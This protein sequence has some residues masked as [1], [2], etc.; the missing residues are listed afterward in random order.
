MAVLTIRQARRRAGGLAVGR[1]FAGPVAAGATLTAVALAAPLPPVAAGALA[2]VAYAAV[3]TAVELGAHADDV[4]LY[5]RAL[6]EPVR[7]R[8]SGAASRLRRDRAAA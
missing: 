7:A 3:L 4:V 1:T 8:L 5:V 6:P 2:L